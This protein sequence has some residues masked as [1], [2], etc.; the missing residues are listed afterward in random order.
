MSQE[1]QRIH[2]YYSGRVQGV[3]FRFVVEHL[4]VNLGLLG[5]V[6]NLADTRVEV[7][8]EGNKDDLDKILAKIDDRF[9]ANIRQKRVNW[10]PARG[11]FDKFE[12]RF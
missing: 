9:S 4:A 6:K 2:V 11:E 3:G 7:V 1:S 12:I 10:M 8:C 5:W